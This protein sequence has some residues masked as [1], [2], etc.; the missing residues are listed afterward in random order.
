MAP[1]RLGK[2]GLVLNSFNQQEIKEKYHCIYIDIY[3]TKNLDEFIYEL[4]KGILTELRPK[5]RKVWETFINMMQSLKSTI[6]FDING[7][8]E[9]SVGLG[10]IAFLDT[11]LDE[12]FSYL[13][14]AE[15][16]CLVAIDEFQTIAGYPEKTVEAAL[17]KRIQNCHNAHFVFLGSKRHLVAQ[18]FTSASRPFYN[19]SA[20]M[21]LDP[22]DMDIYF[23]FA[24]RHLSSIGKEISREAFEYIYSKYDGVTWYIQY[25]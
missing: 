9:W 8:P 10:D 13:N 12:I 16:P 14:N 3:E 21:G 2:S 5:G 20:I 11:T 22:I 7:N 23:E 1:R 18:M 15:K 25:H 24:N 17:R 6:S 19:S 4:G